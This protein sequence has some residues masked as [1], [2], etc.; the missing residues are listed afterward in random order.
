M[1]QVRAGQDQSRF[2]EQI[3]QCTRLLKGCVSA[4]KLNLFR[5]QG[6]ALI[7]TPL[8]SFGFQT[9]IA[10]SNLLG[11][12]VDPARLSV[13]TNTPI[14]IVSTA[15]PT[16]PAHCCATPNWFPGRS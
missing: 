4:E 9:G 11:S 6:V 10:L 3:S 2:S 13:D 12:D 16:L 8:T 5:P 15:L 1:M 7:L 14:E